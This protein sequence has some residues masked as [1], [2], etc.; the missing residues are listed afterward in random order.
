MAN[1]QF[2][3]T[4]KESKL[5]HAIT[6]AK[7]WQRIIFEHTR[8]RWMCYGKPHPG[9]WS[10]VD[11]DTITK[12]IFTALEKQCPDGFSSS[13]LEGVTKLIKIRRGRT[14]KPLSRDY[15]PYRNTVLHV[16][17]MT[18][19]AHT[20]ERGLTWCL[21]YD[22]N[23][24]ATCQPI[25]SWLKETASGD[26]DTVQLLRAYLRAVLLRRVK[27]EKFLEI[28]GQAGSGKG[29]FLRLAQ[30]LVGSHN[31]YVSSL[32]LLEQSR[33]ETVNLIDKQLVVIT[34]EERYTASVSTLKAITGEDTLRGERKFEKS[35][36][37]T[38]QAMVIVAANEAIQSPDYTSGLARRRLTIEFRHHPKVIRDLIYFDEHGEPHGELASSLPGLMNWVLQMDEAT[39][40]NYL[41]ERSSLMMATTKARMLVDTN[42]LAA[43]ANEWLTADINSISRVGIAHKPD[44]STHY[45]HEDDWLYPNYCAYMDGANFKSVS[46]TRF[47]TLLEDLCQHQ[48]GL[49]SV[50]RGRDRHGAHLTGI[51]LRTAAESQEHGFIDLAI[52][53]LTPTSTGRDDSVTTPT[54]VSVDC[55]D[56]DDFS[57]KEIPPPPTPIYKNRLNPSQSSQP[58]PTRLDT[59]SYPSHSVTTGDRWVFGR[60]RQC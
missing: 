18:T 28:I 27:M 45:E 19:H 26:E 60:Q 40:T 5:A 3:P 9:I 41:R 59:I 21:P 47:S 54:L 24:L 2:A 38:N 8:K 7:G 57:I 13:L 29:T 53:P 33:F 46:Q 11:D 32:K 43:W 58:A 49:E 34:D 39:M 48:L 6:Q 55:D 22:Y 10:E 44:H 25:L 15:L 36:T 52:K 4:P 17:T 37:F 35:F 51:R 12:A 23:P 56:C 16:P 50:T 14:L 42:P 31:S 20:P 1:A 30:A